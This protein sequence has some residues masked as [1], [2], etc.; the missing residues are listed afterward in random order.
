VLENF[1][2]MG[3]HLKEL[4]LKMLKAEKEFNAAKNVSK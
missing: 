4:K 1:A 3:E 2:K